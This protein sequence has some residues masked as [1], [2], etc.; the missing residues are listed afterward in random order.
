VQTTPGLSYL[1]ESSTTGTAWNPEGTW[2]QANGPTLLLDA[3]VSN[4]T[5]HFFRVRIRR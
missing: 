1:L 3:P 5:R 2:I 4:A